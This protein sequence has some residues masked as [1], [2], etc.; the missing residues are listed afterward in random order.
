MFHSLHFHFLRSFFFSLF[1]LKE[2]LK[3]PTKKT[4]NPFLDGYFSLPGHDIL[5]VSW[6]LLTREFLGSSKIK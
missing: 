2:K 4:K 5:T 3:S 6:F 1:C